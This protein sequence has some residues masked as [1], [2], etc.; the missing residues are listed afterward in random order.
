MKK[1]TASTIIIREIQ[2]DVEFCEAL[3]KWK[4]IQGEKSN[5]KAV[6]SAVKDAYRYMASFQREQKR[7]DRLVKKLIRVAELNKE[8]NQATESRNEILENWE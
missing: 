6:I 8:I 5:T 4:E 1:I 2:K 7:A 3:A